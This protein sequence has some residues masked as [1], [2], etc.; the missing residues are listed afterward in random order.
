[1]QPT[2]S[3]PDI[4]PKPPENTHAEELSF[5]D[6]FYT[7]HRTE[8]LKWSY[9][10][11]SLTPQEAIDIYQDAVVVLFEN[12]QKGKLTA[13]RSSV[14]TYFYGIAKNLI[15]VYLKKRTKRHTYIETVA[16]I[17]SVAENIPYNEAGNDWM[18]NTL[19]IIGDTVNRL[20]AKGQAIIY[21]FYYEK[22]SLRD[23]TRMLD[24]SSEDVTKTTKMRYK[25]ILRQMV[26]REL[27]KQEAA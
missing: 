25:K 21:L 20:S 9:K 3:N 10:H 12:Y 4:T 11:Y 22:K 6:Q 23:I 24:Y 17:S 2:A 13:L 14:K 16:D 27:I 7:S 18:E 26:Q 15:F 5:L 19:E 1:M 8:F